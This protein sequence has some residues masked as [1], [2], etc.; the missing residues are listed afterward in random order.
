MYTFSG[1]TVGVTLLFLVVFV[2]VFVG[3]AY[4]SRSTRRYA[5]GPGLC[6]D[7]WRRTP[8]GKCVVDP[9]NQGT[10]PSGFSDFFTGQAWVGNARKTWAKTHRIMWDGL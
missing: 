1:I 5:P 6:P 9:S 3:I 7:R 2:L 10:L 8:T 4:L